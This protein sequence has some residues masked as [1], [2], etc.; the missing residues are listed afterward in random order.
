MSSCVERE[1]GGTVPLVFD[2]DIF[3]DTVTRERKR[4]DRSGLAMAMLLI[5]A[6]DS[7][8]DN[9]PALFAGIVDAMAAIKSDIDIV[10]WFE[11]E[12]IMD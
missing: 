1:K 9:R 10:G 3:R 8:H 11:R 12:S 2:E 7:L 4:A 6:Q 5:G